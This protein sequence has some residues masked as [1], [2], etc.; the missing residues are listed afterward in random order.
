M[1]PKSAKILDLLAMSDEADGVLISG[2]GSIFYSKSFPL[3]DELPAFTFEFLAETT[4]V[5][6][7]KAELEQGNTELT[8]AEEKLAHS[9]YVVPENASEIIAS[10][11]NTNVRIAPFLP[12]ATAFARV[13]VT[14]LATNDGTTLTRLRMAMIK[15]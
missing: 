10:I 8:A 12:A 1:I 3:P 2:V 4:S 13:K 15:M 14:G 9:D 7:L 5:M 11:A 6:A